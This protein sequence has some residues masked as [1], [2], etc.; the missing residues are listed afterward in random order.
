MIQLDGIKIHL[1][2]HAVKTGLRLFSSVVI[3]PAERS[4]FHCDRNVLIKAVMFL[5]RGIKGALWR[6]REEIQTINEAITQ[7]VSISE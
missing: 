7:T 4:V 2:S 6:F 5:F 3:Q 1:C